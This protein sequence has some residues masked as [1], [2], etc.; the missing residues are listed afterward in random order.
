[1]STPATASVIVHGHFYQPPRENPWTDEVERQ[2]SAA[3]AH[4]WNERITA[5]CY[6]PNGW[7]RRLDREG[8]I[9][10][11]INNYAGMS[12]DI[13]P[14]LFR[15]LDR[16]AP[17][18]VRRIVEGDRDS[19]V[20]RGGHG[21]A[22]AHPYVHAILPLAHSTDRV[23]L[24]T[25]GIAEFKARFGRAPEGMWLPETGVDLSTLMLLH[26]YGIRYAVLAP[27][28]ATR[29]R[30]LEGERWRELGSNWIDPS[31]PYRCRLPHKGAIDLFFY[32]AGL[33]RAIAFEDL[34]QEPGRLAGRLTEVARN[35]PS[36]LH[37]LCTDG[38]S[39][40][41]HT[42]FGERAMAVVVAQATTS[43]EFSL[44]N[45]GAYLAHTPPTHEVVIREGS[46]WSC[47]HG[48]GRWKE[49][50]GCSTGGQ[51]GWRQR[52]RAPFREAIDG[53]R[54]DLH[55]L[56][57]EQA[58]RF[59]IDVWAARNDYITILLD[60]SDASIGAFFGTHARRP[61]SQQE[62][63]TALQLLEMQR[64]A[65]LMQSSDG[66][67]FSDISDIEAAQNLKHA[68]R[69]LDLASAF[70]TA[71]IEARFLARLQAARSNV[72]AERDGR[73]IWESRVRP[74]RVDLTRPAAIYAIRSL[75]AHLPAPYRIYTFDLHRLVLERLPSINGMAV[76]G[77]VAVSSS[78]TLERKEFGFVLKWSDADGIDGYLFPWRG[79][80]DLYRW[81][82]ICAGQT[83]GG[84]LSSDTQATPITLQALS[85]DECQEILMTLYREWEAL[86]KRYD[87]LAAHSRGLLRAFF[88]AGLA[89]PQALRAPAEFTL[90]RNLEEAL[91][92]WLSD[93]GAG[94]FR[95]LLLL[96]DDARR[97]N[98]PQQQ[99]V[100][101]LLS[102]T[103]T[104][105]LDRLRTHPDPDSL[106]EVQEVLDLTDRLGYTIDQPESVVLMHELLIHDVAPLVER[107]VRTEST[108]EC[109]LVSAIL[110]LCDRF[111]LST[112]GFRQRLHPI[113]ERLAADPGLWP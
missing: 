45:F 28:Q 17:G 52:W 71:H 51:P 55:R 93:G 101:D 75:A 105:R 56:F 74:T 103:F 37:I 48:L 98:L 38:E 70:R 91:Q 62:R 13:G 39:Y 78:L 113:E 108:E 111:G 87:E 25:W 23:T 104:I 19:V 110:R 31:H 59:F 83:D 30:P 54:G 96:A 88:D 5:E 16:K 24:I 94:L 86:R 73:R 77:G 63:A 85:S 107:V 41:H 47:A 97:L 68:A 81:Q 44:T 66:W 112:E 106:R 14:T 34:L 76:A 61:L 2:P 99:G 80:D 18:T 64:H 40:G 11:L 27:W 92:Q 102:R 72:P 95:S 20:R 84:S 35:S 53:L 10:S 67:F 42:R 1:M 7:A 9:V 50:C 109:D 21:N 33:S 29:V 26:E 49:D 65:L 6:C 60:R 90:T 79:P 3:P 57:A 89:P 43:K 15:W 32:D 4:D 58:D 12:F 82:E 36:R 69:A 100:Q 8:R 22:L 46:A